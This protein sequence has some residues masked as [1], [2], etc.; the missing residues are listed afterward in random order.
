M[1]TFTREEIIE[2]IKTMTVLELADLVKFLEEHY[3][4]SANEEPKD[5]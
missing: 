2:K 5:N 3:G 1:G 4:I